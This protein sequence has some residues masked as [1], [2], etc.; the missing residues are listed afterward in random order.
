M[1]LMPDLSVMMKF[2][3]LETSETHLSSKFQIRKI[4]NLYTAVLFSMLKSPI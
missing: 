1:L 3:Y 4:E 2:L